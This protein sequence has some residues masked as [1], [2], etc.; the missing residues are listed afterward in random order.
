MAEKEIKGLHLITDDRYIS[1][2]VF[3]QTVERCLKAGVDVFQFRSK[4]LPLEEQ[5][6]YALWLKEIC[7]RFKVPLIVNDY[8]TVAAEIGADGVHLGAEDMDIAVARK[9]VG[10]RALIGVSCS[11]DLEKAKRA[12][13]AG[14]NYVA[15]GACFKSPTKPDAALVPLSVLTQAKQTLKIPVVAVGGITSKNAEVVLRAGA[16]SIAV[17]SGVLAAVN[18]ANA[19]KAYKEVFLRLGQSVAA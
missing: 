15:F 16:D 11:G 6:R 7:A 4:S 12:Q 9:I 18:P 5:K 14:A 2:A 17:I 1:R 13:D 8:A 3:F 10:D 19:V